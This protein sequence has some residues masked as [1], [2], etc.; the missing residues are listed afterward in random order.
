MSSNIDLKNPK[1]LFF[2][3]PCG[4]SFKDDI[5]LLGPRNMMYLNEGKEFTYNET[6]QIASV[7][8][9]KINRTLPLKFPK[10][11]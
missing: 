8:F 5:Q 6:N 10:K 2:Y 4:K 7:H 3:N 9:G 1:R 11:S